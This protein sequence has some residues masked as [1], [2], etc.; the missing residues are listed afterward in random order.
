MKVSQALRGVVFALLAGICWGLS[1]TMSQYLFTAKGVSSGWLTVWRMLL[2]G[3]ILLTVTAIRKPAALKQVWTVKADTIQLLL[4]AVLGLMAV[5]FSYLQA[6]RYSNAGT[7]T[8]M[9]YS[10][11]AL[12]L[13]Y[14]CI[15][16]RRFP[17]ALEILALVLAL[18]GIYLLATHGDPSNMALS[19]QGLLWGVIAAISLML[20]T[21]LPARLIRKYDSA[22]IT[23]YGL[24]LGG[25]ALSLFVRPWEE[26]V[27]LDGM[28]LLVM[29]GIILIGTVLSFTIYLQSVV[30]IGGVKTGLLASVETIS[31]PFFAVVWLHTSFQ[32]VDYLGF[33]C[34]LLMVVLLAVPALKK[35][36]SSIPF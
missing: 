26:T 2:S 20:Y 29:T 33:G 14:A 13:L 11:E 35:E 17:K 15:T 31:A 3:A 22:S 30:D 16:E 27:T 28:L 34:I 24:L 25:L 36:L 12:I 6:I 19:E 23:G 8:A 18:G 4:F 1:G 5:Q 21:L 10:G 9:Q 7:A 32:P